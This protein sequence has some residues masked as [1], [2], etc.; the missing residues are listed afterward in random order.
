MKHEL[1]LL[2]VLKTSLAK[3]LNQLI[4]MVE[5]LFFFSK[6]YNHFNNNLIQAYDSVL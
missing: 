3:V 2:I 5:V 1:I 4:S 6:M